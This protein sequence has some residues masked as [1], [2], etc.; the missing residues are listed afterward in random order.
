M[1]H[2]FFL[3]VLALFVVAACVAYFAFEGSREVKDLNDVVLYITPEEYN[4]S[5]KVFTLQTTARGQRRALLPKQFETGSFTRDPQFVKQEGYVGP[6]SCKECHADYYEGFIQTAHYH[7]SALADKSSILG[8]FSPGENVMKTKQPGFRFELVSKDNDFFQK[9]LVEQNGTT[10]EHSCRFDIVTGSGNVG[11]T[12]LYWQDEFLFQLPVSWI[13][14]GDRWINSPTYPDGLANFARPIGE[15][16]LACHATNVEF[17]QKRENLV[18]RDHNVIF[19][20]TCERCHGP[21]ESHVNYHRKNPEADAPKFIVHPNDLPRERMNDIC[22]QCHAGG[23]SLL[24]QSPFSFRPG[25]PLGNYKKFRP[26]SGSVGGVHTAN[27]H[28]RLIKSKC[29]TETETMNCATCHNPHQ[30]EHGNIQ[31]FSH[32][33]MK[34]HKMQDCGQFETS[35]ERIKTNCIDCHMP[36]K[37]DTKL[38]IET[39]DEV[40]FPQVRDHY[41]RVDEDA[42]QELLDAWLTEGE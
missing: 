26:H 2:K 25:D 18:N 16:C 4:N 33:C 12:Y 15:K 22:S 11:Q 29:Y 40:I 23:E 14:D 6:E 36:K 30:D 7:T 31:L 27:Q 34:C 38:E 13:S 9:L 1:N 21:A 28:P 5:D 42:T 35:G 10:Y 8:S 39:E 37:D 17:A 24:L 41:I 32:R 19:G 3:I 20:V